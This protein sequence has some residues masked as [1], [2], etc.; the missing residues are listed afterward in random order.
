MTTPQA[1][2]LEAAV[3]RAYLLMKRGL[4]YRPNAMG[5]T[6]IRDEAGRYSAVDAKSHA[7]PISGVTMIA[8]VDAPLFSPKC[9]DDIKVKYL[10]DALSSSNARAVA[11]E[12]ALL[13]H[14]EVVAR[15]VEESGGYW[16][17]CS[18]CYDT[19]DGH[20]TAPYPWSRVFK[21]DQGGGCSECGGL[22]VV[23]DD[24]S[25]VEDMAADFDRERLEEE[26]AKPCQ[27]IGPEDEEG[28]CCNPC[29]AR[30]TLAT[31][32]GA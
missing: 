21:C 8:E 18:G 16:H 27:T 12:E 5:Y 30:T 9:F 3:E 22:G 13:R 4:F 20:P 25:Y 29:R 2:N 24:L 1:D 17:P 26:A 31:L 28:G 7:D 14:A 11:A 19:E 32:K 6:G 15:V 23:W 10:T